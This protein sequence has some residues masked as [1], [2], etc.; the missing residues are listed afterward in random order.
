MNDFIFIADYF[1]NEITGGAEKN[2]EALISLLLLNEFRIDSIKSMNVTVDFIKT[3]LD[4][5]YIIS[6][7]MQLSEDAKTYIQENCFYII[8]EHDHKYVSSKNPAKYIN[9]LA[10]EN[11]IANLDFYSRAFAVICQSKFHAD[12]LYKNTIIQNIISLG[13]NIWDEKDLLILEKNLNSDKTIEFGIFEDMNLIKGMQSAIEYCNNNN[14]N[15]E[16]IKKNNYDKFIQNLAKVKNLVF[17]PQCVETYSRVA[18]ES[19]ILGCNLTTNSL[20]GVSYE[21]YFN[22]KGKELLN[23]IRDNNSKIIKLLISILKREKQEYYI[24]LEIPK[25][26]ICCSMYKAGKYIHH[27]LED[28][29][30][31]TIFDK[32]ELIIA[33]ANSPDNE[34][35]IINKYC[36]IYDNIKY[37]RLDYVASPTETINKI[38]S[39]YSTGTY[40]TIGNVDDRRK[41]TCLQIQA[42]NLMFNKDVDLVYSDCYQ[43]EVPNETFKNN[44][45]NFRLFEHSIQEFSKENMVKC[46]PG[47]IPM[48]RKCVHEKVGLFSEE[49][50]FANDWEMWLRLVNSGFKFKKINSPLGL[51]YFNNDGRSTSPEY[52]EEKLKEESKLFFNNSHLFGQANFNK[53]KNY[54]SRGVK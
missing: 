39:E 34:Q 29:T 20:I 6:N 32:C 9:F 27:F 36:K 33:D 54:F 38:I 35:E 24:P 14:F 22:L 52:N 17:F 8:Y 3:N 45:S 46:L 49:Y 44:T 25:I 15:Y 51:Y 10:P 16:L 31:Q 7:F 42:K 1:L 41:N 47:P 50:R 12:I 43:T 26:T 11:D 48:W 53:Y 23:L 13:G 18:V 30:Q 28:I 21:E 5:K 2:D 19:R 4:K 37:K 40:L